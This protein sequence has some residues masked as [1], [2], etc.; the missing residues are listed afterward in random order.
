[1][2]HR[3][4]SPRDLGV[5]LVALT[6]AVTFIGPATATDASD[7]AVDLT[8]ARTGERAF[9]A[10]ASHALGAATTVTDARRGSTPVNVE[11]TIDG[12]TIRFHV[13]GGGAASAGSPGDVIT[14]S[15]ASVPGGVVPG[16]VR[17]LA[18]DGGS[19][20]SVEVVG[21]SMLFLWAAGEASRRGGSVT[22][23]MSAAGASVL[24]Q[25][26][27]GE[28]AR[29]LTSDELM[30]WADGRIDYDTPMSLEMGLGPVFNKENCGNCHNAPL[31]GPGVQKV[32]RFGA[33]T[34][35]GYDDLAAFGGPLLQAGA[36][37][38]ACVET[39][40]AAANVTTQRVVNG[41]L[42]YGLVEAILDADLLANESTGSPV[43]GRA[44]MVEALEAPGISRVGR[45]GH[46]ASLP[47]VL[48][49]SGD[50]SM[51]EMG[52][53]NRLIPFDNDPNGIFDPPLESCDTVADPED[54]ADENGREFID[55][56]TDFQ[57][58]LAQP[59]QTPRSGMS[60][61]AI[62]NTIGCVQC[63]VRDFTTP[64]DPGLED[65]LQSQDIRP[66][67]DFLLHDMGLAADFI[68]EGDAQQQ[69]HRTPPLWGLRTRPALWHDGRFLGDFET[70]TVAAIEEHGAFLSE[71]GD[72]A[73]A[74]GALGASDRAALLAFLDS[75]GRA[76][77]DADGDDDVELDDWFDF[78]SC[79][80]QTGITA[81]DPCA[82]HDLDQDGDVDSDDFAGLLS[83]YDGAVE[84]CNGNGI[85]D[86]ADITNGTSMDVDG[87]G[88]PDEC[89][90]TPCPA[91]VDMS[92]DVAF[93]DLLSVLSA[94]GDSCTC[95]QDVTGNG[96]VG[97]DDVL[98]VLSAWGPC[99][100]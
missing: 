1:M 55:R 100:G 87:D 59:P 27:M 23:E 29:G 88:V 37:S 33:V 4:R 41:M 32:T 86:I 21:D 83:V 24:P 78:M 64:N 89:N 11:S 45:F 8:V 60:G 19:I 18:A 81:D 65:F 90:G 75:L 49:F 93:P 53:T 26:R 97:F 62:F 28:P 67:A 77:F 22:I 66:Y 63:H 7:A 13:D 2:L 38:L 9:R 71:A 50:A 43:S 5:A 54:F 91:D 52:L 73:A 57:R 76:E 69:E 3:T 80:G 17:L 74:F 34:K 42:G 56:V 79:M 58:F 39:L 48:S 31:G 6:A 61:E 10:T 36:I 14:V 51:M 82:I 98:V 20:G 95:P 40:P 16:S 44:H 30:R 25:R 96:V 12:R 99:K 70:R 35:D 15:V 85:I 84:D 94:F 68:L 72:S 47:T 92:G 46:K